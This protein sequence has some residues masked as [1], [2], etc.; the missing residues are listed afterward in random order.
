M[1]GIYTKQTV[2]TMRY[3]K[4]RLLGCGKSC[5]VCLTEDTSTCSLPDTGKKVMP[6][7]LSQSWQPRSP[8]SLSL[9]SGMLGK[10]SKDFGTLLQN[11]DSE[12]Q[13]PLAAILIMSLSNWSTQGESKIQKH[14]ISVFLG[15]RKEKISGQKLIKISISYEIPKPIQNNKNHRSS[16]A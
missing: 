7:F 3:S 4:M 1:Q 10:S 8:R 15:K 16:Y 12:P 13:E 9:Q 6:E 14:Y 2:H 11:C 5:Q